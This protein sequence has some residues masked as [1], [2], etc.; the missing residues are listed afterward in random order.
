MIS[1]NLDLFLVDFALTATLNGKTIRV[2]FDENF[3]SFELG[4]EGRSI[5]ATGKTSDLE[6]TR[7][8]DAIE[9]NGRSF[10][11]VGVQ[12]QGDGAF[13]QLVLKQ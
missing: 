12:P 8:G 1:E 3:L 7:H 5:T 6:G 10:Q 4:A 2:L 11:V 13:T 9:I